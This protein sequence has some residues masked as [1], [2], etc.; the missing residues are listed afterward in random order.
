MNDNFF[1]DSGSNK[2]VIDWCVIDTDTVSY[3]GRIIKRKKKDV[4]E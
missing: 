2:I 4:Y 1:Q 3:G